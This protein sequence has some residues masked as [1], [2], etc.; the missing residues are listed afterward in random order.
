MDARGVR[1]RPARERGGALAWREVRSVCVLRAKGSAPRLCVSRIPGLDVETLRREQPPGAALYLP[2]SR[3]CLAVIRRYYRGKIVTLRPEEADA[4]APLTAR[5][6]EMPPD[7]DAPKTYRFLLFWPMAVFAGA[8]SI[9]FAWMLARMGVFTRAGFAENPFA[10][11][12]L[13]LILISGL[14]CCAWLCACRV[15][16]DARGVRSPHPRP[17]GRQRLHPLEGGALRGR[18]SH[19]AGRAAFVRLR[20]PN[21]WVGRDMMANDLPLD[22]LIKMGYSRRR[23][24]VIRRYCR[25]EMVELV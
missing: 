13:L 16:M 1:A 12:L 3:R 23:L 8:V 15:T 10:A 4:G 7:A 11:C 9:A 18:V 5:P 25:G 22:D 17:A 2:Y 24:A 6:L 14:A 19:G 21:V 20:L